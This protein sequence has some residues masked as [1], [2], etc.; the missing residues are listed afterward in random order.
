MSQPLANSTV[1]IFMLQDNPPGLS[2]EQPLKLVFAENRYAEFFG[3]GQLAAGLL[4]GY[5]VVTLT[6]DAGGEPGAG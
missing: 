6:G 5:N 3:L 4:A 2:F 1:T